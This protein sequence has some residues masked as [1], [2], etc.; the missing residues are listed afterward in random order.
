MLHGKSDT[1]LRVLLELHRYAGLLRFQTGILALYFKASAVIKTIQN[2][3]I[4]VPDIVS[5][6][7]RLDS[8]AG[9]ANIRLERLYRHGH[10][11]ARNKAQNRSIVG[12]CQPS[13][14]LIPAK[15]A[16]GAAVS[17]VRPH[18]RIVFTVA[19]SARVKFKFKA[20]CYFRHRKN[21]F[22]YFQCFTCR[23]RAAFDFKYSIAGRVIVNKPSVFGSING[24]RCSAV[25]RAVFIG[26]YQSDVCLLAQRIIHHVIKSECFSLRG[27]IAVYS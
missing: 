24:N 19:A 16:K 11:V 2:N 15:S 10:A 21:I 18:G 23:N 25:F 8:I 26:N 3:S 22:R 27:R 17:S 13:V 12:I 5:G 4:V 6:K 9:L 1:N 20:V 14:R 7:F